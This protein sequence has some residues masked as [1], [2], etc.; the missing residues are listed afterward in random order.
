MQRQNSTFKNLSQLILP[1]KGRKRS[2]LSVGILCIPFPKTCGGRS[3][4]RYGK[5]LSS[6]LRIRVSFTTRSTCSVVIKICVNPLCYTHEC[7]TDLAAPIDSKI[8][9][10]H[11]MDYIF[12]QK[13]RLLELILT[14]TFCFFLTT[15]PSGVITAH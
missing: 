14:A 11:H 2:L 1:V 4:I 15:E 9:F 13:V 12:S 6:C 10:Y 3:T 5:T 7:I 8:H